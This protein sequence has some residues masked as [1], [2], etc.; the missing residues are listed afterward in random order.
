MRES[1][2]YKVS[3]VFCVCPFVC[4]GFVCVD[5]FTHLFWLWS[6]WCRFVSMSRY[7]GDVAVVTFWP[8]RDG[9]RTGTKHHWP[10]K[11]KPNTRRNLVLDW[12]TTRNDSTNKTNKASEPA[13]TQRYREATV[14]SAVGRSI[15]SATRTHKDP[16]R[17]KADN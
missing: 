9:K 6:L 13:P 4:V 14:L 11:S 3:C 16:S 10:H 8:S 17:G 1:Q 7:E 2:D 15:Q 5:P 12:R